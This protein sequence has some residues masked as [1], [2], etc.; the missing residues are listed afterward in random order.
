MKRAGVVP[1]ASHPLIL[2]LAAAL[3][4]GGP[5]R[6]AWAADDGVQALRAAQLA[7]Q[8]RCEEAL[9]LLGD[10]PATSA[11]LAVLRGKCLIELRR[12][13]EA[14]E[15]L[16]RARQLEPGRR[17]VALPLAIARFHQGDMVGARQAIG[18]VGP[19]GQDKAEYH[20][21]RGLLLLQQAES[22]Q[23][24]AA[25]DRARALD[26]QG[27]DPIASY[28]AGLA[29]AG[30]EDRQRA[31]EAL[32]RVEE[33]APGS[34]WADQARRALSRLG[35]EEKGWWA[36]V[37]AGFEYDD[38]VVLRGSGVTLPAEIS[39]THDVRGVWQF[40]GGYE[41]LRTPD[42]SGGVTATYYGSAH[43]DL[44][45]FDQHYPVLG[46][47]LDRRLSESATFRAR[48][49]AGYAWVDNDPFLFSQ[50]LSGT[51]FQDWGSRGRSRLLVHGYR[52]NYL[53]SPDNDVPDGP[54]AAN[55]S[56]LDFGDIVCGPPGVDES[57][58]RNRDGWGLTGGLDHTLPLARL[59]T[60][61]TGGYFYHYFDARGSEYSFQGHEV[62]LE[63]LSQLPWGLELRGLV[64]YTYKPYR[65]A[66]TFPDPRDLRFNREYPLQSADR[67][68]DV[69]RFAVE[70]E[71]FWTGK[72][73]TSI[74]YSYLKN[75]SNVTVFDYD[76][77]ITGIYVTYRFGR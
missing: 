32:R 3:L 30:A 40:T 7:R 42:W 68:D 49:D 74:R 51:L 9:A 73:S 62:R 27:V 71:K 2:A 15:A 63:S 54:G 11:E 69:W 64:S 34:E 39:S 17:D 65:H 58:E 66:S 4:L 43:F 22:A 50:S 52:D 76:R 19:E 48:Y 77:E 28:Y 60:E 5:A 33:V 16:D 8:G 10:G 35:G 46:V 59:R 24:G 55:A 12:Y 67:Q 18:E 41:L 75:D 14:V 56:C 61:L 26:P 70:L 57:L 23:A 20:L 53:F 72:L 29:W 38:N 21:Y 45:E 25:L 44:S 47:W 37:R 1:L 13:P 36:W 31:E 6:G